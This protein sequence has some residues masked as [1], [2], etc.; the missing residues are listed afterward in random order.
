MSRLS[1]PSVLVTATLFLL[2]ELGCSASRP[3][4]PAEEEPSEP[5]EPSL[6]LLYT[7]ADGDL[8]LRD[9]RRD[10]IR[11]IETRTTAA[12]RSREVSPTGR[13]LA[14]S[15]TTADSSHLGLLDLTTHRLQHMHAL[16]G[17]AVYSVAWHPSEDQFAFGHYRTTDDQARGPGSIRIAT[18][19]GDSRDLGCQSVREVL[20]WFAD[21]TLATRTQETLHLV[22]GDDCTTH[23]SQDARRMHHITYAPDGQRKAYIH[24]ELTYDRSAREYVP[25]SSLIVSNVGGRN[26]ETVF[27][28][29]RQPRHL[30]WSPDGSELAVDVQPD[31]SAHRQIVIFDGDRTVFLTP[32]EQTTGDQVHPRWSPSGDRV[33]FTVRTTGESHA[34]VR[35]KGRTQRLAPT[36]GPVWG[37]LDDQTVVVPGPDSLRVQTLSGTTRHRHPAPATLLHVWQP[38]SL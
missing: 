31:E 3:S 32:P 18:P 1:L 17:E 6:S 11:R 22:S 25:D 21:G 2:F 13:Y 19:D 15:Y 8:L 16:A 23:S 29:E 34:A 14:F 10:S 33:A 36:D 4:Q 35:V 9:G 30:R 37:W 26:S 20:H 28:D 12:D 27:G 24:R 38:P 7:T 5:A